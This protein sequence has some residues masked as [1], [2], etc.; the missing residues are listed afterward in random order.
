MPPMKRSSRGFTLLELMMTIGLASLIAGIGVPAFREWTQNGRLTGAA[1]EMLVTIV[2]ARNEAV[3]RQTRTSFCP[4][5]APDSTLAVCDDE[6]TAGFISFVDKN[7]NCQRD[8]GEDLVSSFVKHTQVISAHNMSCIGYSPSGFRIPIAGQPVNAH[9]V[10]C[11]K[12]G[13][14]PVASGS[15]YSL[16]RGVEIVATGRAAVT[17]LYDELNLWKGGDSPVKCN[18]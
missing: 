5:P 15:N 2:T 1:N 18:E 9:A 14:N 17:R 13:I 10:F 6:A 16:G 3:R 7:N 11:D 4:S 8:T 12:R